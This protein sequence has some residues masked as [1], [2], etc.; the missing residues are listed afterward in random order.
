MVRPD[1]RDVEPG[2]PRG[3]LLRADTSGDLGLVVE[4]E[5]RDD[6][7]RRDRACRL[8]RDHELVEVEERLDHEEVDAAAF[9]HARL[10]GV[11]RSVLGRVE[12]LELAER[13]DRAGDEDVSAGDLPRLARQA[14][15]GRVELL[16]RVVEHEA[17]ELPPVRAEGVRL[18]QL[19]A[20]GN[21]ARV[22][23]DDALRRA[24]VRLLRAAQ[25][26]HGA[27]DERA[28]PAVGDERRAVAE[29]FEKAAHRTRHCRRG[30]RPAGRDGTAAKS[31]LVHRLAPP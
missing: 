25:P 13:A 31:R 24:D 10:L 27:R 19:G 26:G 18:D 5:Q 2:K 7:Q 30:G 14:H 3:G 1:R 8:D 17:R 12:H 20:R 23:R 22:H 9:E 6:R 16:E 28:H 21:V 11:E 15:P 29:T 4:G